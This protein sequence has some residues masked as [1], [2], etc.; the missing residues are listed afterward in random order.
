[1]AIWIRASAGVLMYDANFQ[2]FDETLSEQE[3]RGIM[4]SLDAVTAV[5]LWTIVVSNGLWCIWAI[6]VASRINHRR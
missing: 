1:M 3:R 4:S 6:V 2:T 5:L